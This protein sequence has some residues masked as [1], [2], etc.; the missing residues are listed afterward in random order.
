[1]W[2]PEHNHLSTTHF[3]LECVS[4]TP[5]ARYQITPCLQYFS[6][7]MMYWSQ[8]SFCT[9]NIWTFFYLIWSSIL[10]R[11]DLWDYM[12]VIDFGLTM[13]VF[14]ICMGWQCSLKFW[15]TT[16]WLVVCKIE[17]SHI[18][19]NDD[20]PMHSKHCD[21]CVWE[22]IHIMGVQWTTLCL[23]CL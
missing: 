16:M 22:Q 11:V 19:F 8:F 9:W 13:E 2:V 3:A 23:C 12:L 18:M 10:S 14:D 5:F 15:K 7:E 6:I 21:K 17:Y 1:M 20:I 4:N